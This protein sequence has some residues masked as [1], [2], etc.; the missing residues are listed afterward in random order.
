VRARAAYELGRTGAAG[1]VPEL[2]KATADEQAL[3]RVAATR[4]LEWLSGVPAARRDLQRTSAALESRLAAG[5]D[6]ANVRVDEDLRR[7][8]VK[9]SRL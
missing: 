3:V 7:L 9:L 5:S 1:A 4:A 2:S 8:Q 6:A